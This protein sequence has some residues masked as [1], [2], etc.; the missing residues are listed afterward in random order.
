MTETGPDN[1]QDN[2]PQPVSAGNT[3]ALRKAL[4]QKINGKTKP[5]GSLGA[6]ERIALQAGLVFGTTDPVITAPHI[7]VFAADHGIAVEGVS[8]YPQAVTAQMVLNF[9]Q[10]G[11]AINV[12]CR[13]HDIRLLVVDAGVQS[14]F[15]PALP[16]VH[17]KTGRGTR[18]FR[19]GP[20]MDKRTMEKGLQQGRQTVQQIARTGCNLV[21]FGEMGIGNTSSA[22]VLMSLLCNIPLE[23]CI[24][25][26]TGVDDDQ[27][28]HKHRVLRQAVDAYEGT[29]CSGRRAGL[30]RRVRDRADGRGHDG[31]LPAEHAG[32]WWMDLFPPPLFSVP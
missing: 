29:P 13:Q 22:A 3:E 5:P 6:L 12:F 32:S 28:L 15:D 21:G 2:E 20:A 17:Q 16:L 7:V 26:G 9:V 8:A 10:G 1:K 27:L 31:S 24:G 23:E 30:V 25:R 4:L 11:A 19:Y 14:D 18:S